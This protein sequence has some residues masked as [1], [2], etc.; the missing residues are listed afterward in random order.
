MPSTHQMV[1]FWASEAEHVGL[2]FHN[3]PSR[4][5]GAAAKQKKILPYEVWAAE[6]SFNLEV[7]VDP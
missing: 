4:H 1:R 7:A 5:H 6:Q 2:E 3:G